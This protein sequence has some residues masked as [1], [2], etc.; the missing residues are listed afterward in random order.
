MLRKVL[1][2]QTIIW[3]Y[4]FKYEITSIFGYE[5]H[6]NQVKVTLPAS[7]CK[8]VAKLRLDLQFLNASLFLLSHWN[9]VLYYIIFNQI[10][11]LLFSHWMLITGVQNYQRSW[12]HKVCVCLGQVRDTPRRADGPGC[13]NRGQAFRALVYCIP[14]PTHTLKRQHF[15]TGLNQKL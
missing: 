3:S 14:S 13:C 15:H 9:E 4:K 6:K 2:I 12:Y 7:P 1:I 8:F 5:L 10:S 11:N